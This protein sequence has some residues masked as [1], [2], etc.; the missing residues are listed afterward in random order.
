MTFREKVPSVAREADILL[1]M[2]RLLPVLLDMVHLR[3]I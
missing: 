3:S 1:C 2:A